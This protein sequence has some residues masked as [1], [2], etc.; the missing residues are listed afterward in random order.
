MQSPMSKEVFKFP[1]KNIIRKY[2]KEYIFGF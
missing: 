2:L 1:A